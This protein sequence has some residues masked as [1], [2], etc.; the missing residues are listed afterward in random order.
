M[1][2]KD[3]ILIAQAIKAEVDQYL[4]GDEPERQALRLLADQLAHRLL[5]DNNRFDFDRFIKACGF[6]E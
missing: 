5:Q 2:R 1:T 6:E 4:R 3:Y